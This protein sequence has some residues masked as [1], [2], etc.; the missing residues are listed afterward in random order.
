MKI[1]I[2]V[3]LTLA[4][5]TCKT[6]LSS[7]S[8]KY[9]YEDAVKMLK[10]SNYSKAADA[11]NYLIEQDEIN[12]PLYVLR[13][14]AF[15]GLK[16]YSEAITDYQIAEKYEYT[17]AELYF[18]FALCYLNTNEKEAGKTYFNKSINKD[19]NY[20]ESYIM[21]ADIYYNDK[22]IPNA[23]KNYNAAYKIKPSNSYLLF[24]MGV[25][26]I[27]GNDFTGALDFF[28][29]AYKIDSSKAEL[30]HYLSIAY[31][32]LN[33]TGNAI[34]YS[35]NAVKK[36]PNNGIYIYSLANLYSNYGFYDKSLEYYTALINMP[37]NRI[38]PSLIYQ[39]RGI[40]NLKIGNYENALSDFD[41][42][43]L[44]NPSDT[45]SFMN[46][47]VVHYEQGLDSLA[48]E[49]FCSVLAVDT[50]NILGLMYRG[51]LYLKNNLYD[52]AYSDLSRAVKIKPDDTFIQFSL[53]NYYYAVEKYM[54]AIKYYN[55][56][57]ELDPNYKIVLEN[58][59]ICYYN[60]H[61]YRQAAVDFDNAMKYD[62]RLTAKLKPLWI[63][64]RVKAGI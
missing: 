12:I 45:V 13:G 24:K 31:N 5:L 25:I 21:L 55:K 9:S 50:N 58:R 10:D 63:D 1:F 39:K 32:G 54:D 41:N 27:G 35:L 11:L 3:F 6:A 37:D 16:K 51:N 34:F 64:A 20:Y 23:V 18:K 53:G 26:S 62:P 59:G 49:E 14:N 52:S 17:S 15:F 22:D 30:N 4:V 8:D 57:L 36:E 46:K 29:Q 2:Y 56:T 38:S 44:L 43:I 42:A 40:T 47:G 19:A 7:D 48:M 28:K 60:L 33:D 61:F